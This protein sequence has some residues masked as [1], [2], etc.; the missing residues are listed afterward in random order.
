MI[1]GRHGKKNQQ[2]IAD[3]LGYSNAYLSQLASGEKPVTKKVA[4]TFESHFGINSLWLLGQTSS[5]WLQKDEPARTD[6]DPSGL[7][8]VRNRYTR[9]TNAIMA[10][11]NLRTEKEVCAALGVNNTYFSNIKYGRGSMRPNIKKQLQLLFG[12]NPDYLDGNSEIIF[13][14]GGQTNTIN[15]DNNVQ[16]SSHVTMDNS[17]LVRRLTEDNEELHKQLAIAN[18]QLAAVNEQ[19][20]KSQDHVSRLIAMLEKGGANG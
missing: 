10:R 13:V 11:F 17:A 12:V 9:L 16:N 5:P 1:I 4:Q 2:E 20:R 6:T 19:L 18:E 7:Q 3:E 14:N 15:G 8:D